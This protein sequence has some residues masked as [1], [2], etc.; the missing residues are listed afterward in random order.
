MKHKVFHKAPYSAYQLT[1]RTTPAIAGSG[2]SLSISPARLLQT[3]DS[4]AH[5][6]C[7]GNRR[8]KN[9][10]QIRLNLTPAYLP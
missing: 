7:D 1:I 2:I 8:E 5:H 9:S 3:A 6:D 4:H 10:L